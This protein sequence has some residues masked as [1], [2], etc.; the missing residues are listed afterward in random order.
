MRGSADS[1]LASLGR[2]P[3][4]QRFP[5]G[6]RQAG[7]G[8]RSDDGCS[9]VQDWSSC[10]PRPYWRGGSG[11]GLR[12]LA[13]MPCSFPPSGDR[14]HCWE[15]LPARE[16]AVSATCR[17][18]A[19]SWGKT[20]AEHPKGIPTSARMPASGPAPT[21][22]QM[23]ITAPQP[24]PITPSTAPL[25]GTLEIPAGP[26]DDGPP[27][28]LTLDRAID[29]TLERSLDLRGEYLRSLKPEPTSSRPACGPTP[30]STRRPA[31][32]I[33]GSSSAGRSRAARASTISTSTLPLDVSH[34]RQAR[35]LVAARPRRSWRRSTRRRSGSGSMNLRCLRPGDPGGAADAPLFAAKRQGAGKPGRPDRGTLQGQE[36]LARGPEPGEDPAPDCQAR[37][38][39]RRGGLPQGQARPGL[40]DEPDPRGGRDARAARDRSATRLPRLRA[41]RSCGGSPSNPAPT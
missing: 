4:R 29:I 32:P 37:A 18:P 27:D 40:A 5:A 39:R 9:C 30:S 35:T 3:H 33:P 7:R 34:K 26:E 10:W 25:Y 16:E 20:R 11:Q 8:H 41:S 24:E 38:S 21:A 31:P 17:A 1:E 13:A 23:A 2:V 22:Y 15:P 12:P 28:G 6:C 19:A 36:R 14:L